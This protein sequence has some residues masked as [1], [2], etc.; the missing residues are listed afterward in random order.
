MKNKFFNFLG[1]KSEQKRN[2]VAV[3]V[4]G[5]NISSKLIPEVFNQIEKEGLG[6]VCIKNLYGNFLHPAMGDYKYA[7][8]KYR[9][10]PIHQFSFVKGKNTT[11]FE[12]VMD[13]ME[14]MYKDLADT[15]CLVSSDS[16]FRGLSIRLQNE[17]KI[18]VYGFGTDKTSENFREACTGFFCIGSSTE[19]VDGSDIKAIMPSLVDAVK[20]NK[21]PDRWSY[22]PKVGDNLKRILPD[23]DVKKFGFKTMKKMFESLHDS[24]ELEIRKN[25]G[26]EQCFVRVKTE[27]QIDQTQTSNSYERD[28]EGY[29]FEDQF[30]Y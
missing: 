19:T 13:A 24:F 30:V 3:L 17:G 1:F 8:T 18:K 26:M 5:D 4:D 20:N 25:N 9:M 2:R 6:D 11:D 12:I 15:I 10:L 14:I 16:D 27:V 23:F 28:I 21:D 7:V 29:S 22:L